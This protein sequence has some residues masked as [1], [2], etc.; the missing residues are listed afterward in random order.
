MA[1]SIVQDNTA[2]VSAADAAGSAAAPANILPVA[3]E[4]DDDACGAS[5]AQLKSAPSETDDS[6]FESSTGSSGSSGSVV[7][8][9]FCCSQEVRA[10]KC[11]FGPEC[12]K[13]M[14]NINNAEV[15]ITG[16]KGERWEQWEAT[17][18][19]GGPSLNSVIMNYRKQVGDAKGRG[20]SRGQFD[21]MLA[22]EEM[23]VTTQTRAGVKLVFM[24]YGWWLEIAQAQ[25]GMLMADAVKQWDFT[26]RNCEE[27]HKKT[28]NGETWLAMPTED[29]IVGENIAAHTKVMALQQKAVKKPSTEAIAAAE[30]GLKQNHLGFGDKAFESCGGGSVLVTSRSGGSIHFSPHGKSLMCDGAGGD[31]RVA[32]GAKVDEE[33][34][35][36][37]KTKKNK[38]YDIAANRN[39]LQDK[40]QEGV[41][42]QLSACGTASKEAT[43]LALS[44]ADDAEGKEKHSR[45]LA[46]MAERREI[47][48]AVTFQLDV[49]F[50]VNDLP[51]IVK[52]DVGAVK[53][54]LDALNVLVEAAVVAQNATSEVAVWTETFSKAFALH[55]T[56]PELGPLGTNG[57][58]LDG[59]FTLPL[60]RELLVLAMKWTRLIFVINSNLQLRV[61]AL[62]S[63][64]KPL[65]IEDSE[66]LMPLSL[67]RSGIDEAVA[68][69]M[70][71]DD[72]KQS[73]STFK[74]EVE[75]VKRL[76][77]SV[78]RSTADIK[79]A[80]SSKK[81]KASQDEVKVQKAE[82]K[83]QKDLSKEME[84]KDKAVAGKS[85][86]CWLPVFLGAADVMTSSF[87]PIP[88]FEDHGQF[89]K[90]GVAGQPFHSGGKPYMIKTPRLALAACEHAGCKSMMQIFETQFPC[91]KQAKSSGRAQT[92]LKSE[93]AKKVFEAFLEHK[94]ASCSILEGNTDVSIF[95]FMDSMVYAGCEYNAVGSMRMALKGQREVVLIGFADFWDALSSDTKKT[96]NINEEY[97]VT[98]FAG[99]LLLRLG[100]KDALTTELLAKAAQIIW[101]GVVP[102]KALLYIPPGFMLCERAMN[103]ELL[104]G[105]RCSV[106]DQ[107]EDA[108][109]HLQAILNVHSTYAA[110]DSVMKTLWEKAL[111]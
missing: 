79:R 34:G 101:H 104:V 24:R 37:N 103:K 22:Y 50:T 80:E 26:D 90:A 93:N 95:G 57:G 108:R 105:L 62:Q 63:E 51:D 81:R 86:E 109:R 78:Q 54:T 15:K 32:P 77:S 39:L 46:T 10:P 23:K 49:E 12:K 44:F 88:A 19:K 106:K 100:A 91:S 67:L 13:A 42:L 17:K 66:Q 18:K 96:A 65:P 74:S 55:H 75:R 83:K 9:C 59:K 47:L 56:L 73:A 92:P 36:Q 69:C 20:S 30:T 84:R 53:K 28:K 107:S 40:M 3:F 52:K 7:G 94:H 98:S 89:T 61:K 102:A 70:T 29:Y 111:V 35:G 11:V 45:Y 87:K 16:K 82:V 85:G 5:P 1:E 33:D 58:W 72:I 8:S 43:D 64:Q 27:E 14:N 6:V 48:D 97:T 68:K 38:N 41:D 99:D 76:V 4:F 25:Q 71:E 31:F 60:N 110:K 2:A 21:I